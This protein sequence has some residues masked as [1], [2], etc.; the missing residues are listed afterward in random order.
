MP[1]AMTTATAPQHDLFTRRALVAMMNFAT[2]LRTTAR[3]KTHI[4]RIA[5]TANNGFNLKLVDFAESRKLSALRNA[6][7]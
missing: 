1:L 7:G 3:S 6:G 2:K 5:V 4:L